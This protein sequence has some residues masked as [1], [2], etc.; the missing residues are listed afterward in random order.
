MQQVILSEKD[1]GMFPK[2]P[3]TYH[4]RYTGQT[5]SIC[6]VVSFEGENMPA[7]YGGGTIDM[8]DA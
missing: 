7:R 1:R 5:W 8:V 4:G 3:C 6:L 2:A